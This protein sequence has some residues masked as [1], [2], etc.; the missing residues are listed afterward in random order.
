MFHNLDQR[1][2]SSVLYER[3]EHLIKSTLSSFYLCNSP[4]RLTKNSRLRVT[5]VHTELYFFTYYYEKFKLLKSDQLIRRFIFSN[6]T[7]KSLIGECPITKCCYWI[8]VIGQL[9]KPITS[10]IPS[11]L[12]NQQQEK[13]YCE[14]R[15]PTSTKTKWRV[16]YFNR[17]SSSNKIQQ[18]CLLFHS[19]I[20]GIFT[21]I[22]NRT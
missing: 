10:S 1:S 15:Q 20:F 3:V 19:L 5:S 4:I 6:Q 8:P 12:T 2:S 13:S 9:N 14:Q 21:T 17:N 22:C 18:L 11:F 7:A 16:V